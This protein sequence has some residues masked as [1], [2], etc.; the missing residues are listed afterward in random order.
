MKL[1]R[2]SVLA[3]AAS[4]FAAP[5]VVALPARAD[6]R[7]QSLVDACLASGQKV[8]S[9]KDFPDA[10]KLMSGARGVLIIP[11][12]VQGGTYRGRGAGRSFITSGRPAAMKSTR[13]ARSATAMFMRP[14]AS[15][16]ERPR[17]VS[18][19][20]PRPS[21]LLTKTTGDA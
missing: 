3:G 18:G 13:S 21:S 14:M 8:L 5:M 12:L 9:G 2:R 1:D 17:G 16:N 15:R 11:E 4:A 10:V 6:A 7:R 19:T 20:R